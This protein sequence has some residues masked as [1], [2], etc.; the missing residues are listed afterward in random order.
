V[1]SVRPEI[2]EIMRYLVDREQNFGCLS[3]CRYCADCAQN[4][5]RGVNRREKRCRTSAARTLNRGK[6]MYRREGWVYSEDFVCK[7][8]ELVFNAFSYFPA[9]E[10]NVI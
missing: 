5:S 9:S 7:K 10:E 8:Q 6:V 3:N 1:K 2:G 4:E